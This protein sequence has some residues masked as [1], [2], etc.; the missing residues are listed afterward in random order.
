MSSLT[1]ITQTTMCGRS[2]RS[3]L[4]GLARFL[5]EHDF[6]AHETLESWPLLTGRKS[7]RSSLTLDSP[8]GMTESGDALEFGVFPGLSPLTWANFLEIYSS[9]NQPK[10]VV[11][12]GTFPGFGRS[13]DEDGEAVIQPVKS[14][15]EF[16]GCTAYERLKGKIRFFDS[17]WCV[18][19]I[20]TLS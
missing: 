20:P 10:Q 15:S 5:A 14:L 1:P 12:R 8:L 16:D 13:L 6:R 3:S 9:T 7:L 11:G 2:E 19:W 18:S 17:D 4:D